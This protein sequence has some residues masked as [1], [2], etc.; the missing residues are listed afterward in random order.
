MGGSGATTIT[1]DHLR[2][3]S[4]QTGSPLD[5]TCTL[6]W[7][8]YTAPVLTVSDPMPRLQHSTVIISIIQYK[9]TFQ[10]KTVSTS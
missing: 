7:C 1:A 5:S 6:C 3:E 4:E 10:S 8:Q 2:M 9:N